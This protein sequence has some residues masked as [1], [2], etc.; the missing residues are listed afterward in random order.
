MMKTTDSG[1]NRLSRIAAKQVPHRSDERFYSARAD[2][3]KACEDFLHLLRTSSAHDVAVKDFIK[4]VNRLEQDLQETSPDESKASSV[5]RDMGKEV[6]HLQVAE[7]WVAASHRVL[8][9]LGANASTEMRVGLEEGRERVMWCVRAQHWDGELTSTTTQ[10][11]A[12]V[13]EAEAH[14]ARVAS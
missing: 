14:A 1:K 12:L 6:L 5:V 7:T 10:L 9:R 4:A 11:E 8:D 3:K 13:K 2:V